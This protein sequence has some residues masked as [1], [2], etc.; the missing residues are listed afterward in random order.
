MT[1]VVNTTASSNVGT[2][3][4]AYQQ[5][6]HNPPK[7]TAR[8][9]CLSAYSPPPLFRTHCN[10]E[11]SFPSHQAHTIYSWTLL[12]YEV[13]A[14]HPARALRRPSAKAGQFI[15]RPKAT[16]IRRGYRAN[17]ASLARL[18]ARLLRVPAL[19][20]A[21]FAPLGPRGVRPLMRPPTG[22]R[23]LLRQTPG[24]RPLLCRAPGAR[25]LLRQAPGPRPLLRPPSGL[26]LTRGGDFFFFAATGPRA[27]T[28]DATPANPP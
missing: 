11:P 5:Q 27:R 26:V 24:R 16:D 17:P 4:L 3:S 10:H 2:T 19:P 25:P 15:R 14:G 7:T 20:Y 8:R 23:P 18:Q 12:R 9:A 28:T 21:R 1:L 6:T 22:P 13:R